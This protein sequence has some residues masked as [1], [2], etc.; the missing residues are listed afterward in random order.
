[1]TAG[2][3]ITLPLSAIAS[4]VTQP[5]TPVAIVAVAAQGMARSVVGTARKAVRSVRCRNAAEQHGQVAVA[6]AL[7]EIVPSVGLVDRLDCASGFP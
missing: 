2:S 3:V 7:Q 6:V 5:T 1:M 4:S